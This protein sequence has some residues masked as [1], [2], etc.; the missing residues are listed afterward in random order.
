[1]ASSA[2]QMQTAFNI[3]T[4]DG[5]I[6]LYE[7][8]EYVYLKSEYDTSGQQTFKQRAL[9]IINNLVSKTNG[10]GAPL[11]ATGSVAAG[12]T[13]ASVSTTGAGND[14]APEWPIFYQVQDNDKPSDVFIVHESTILNIAGVNSVR[15]ANNWTDPT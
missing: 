14:T 4:W 6:P 1:M 12:S 7:T 5:R 9:K 11:D 15:D 8:D 2:A 3:T 13:A 10:S